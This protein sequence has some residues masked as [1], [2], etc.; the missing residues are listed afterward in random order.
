MMDPATLITAGLWI[1]AVI[2]V[3]AGIAGLALPALPGA[4]LL[5]CGLVIAAWAENLKRRIEEGARVAPKNSA[6]QNA[7]WLVPP[8]VP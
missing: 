2:L 5:F 8:S 4:P 3:I 1:L 7:P 6:H